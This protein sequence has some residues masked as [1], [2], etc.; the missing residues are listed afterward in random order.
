MQARPTI[1]MFINW[2]TGLHG[3]H[4]LGAADSARANGANLVCFSGKELGHPDHF[5]S[6][7]SVVFDLAKAERVDGLIVW[8]TTLQ[9]FVGREAMEAFCHRFDPVPMVSVEQSMAGMPSLV[10][11]EQQGMCEVVSHLIE[12]HGHRRIA[13]VRG[14]VNHPGAQLRYLGYVEALVRHGIAVDETL[15]SSAPRFWRPEESAAM[16]EQLLDRTAGAIDAIATA[17]DDLALGAVWALQNRRIRVP[18]D[19]AVV[20]FDD[21]VNVD[22][23]DLGMD[24]MGQDAVGDE[25][26]GL[27]NSVTATLPLTTVRSPMYQLGWRSVEVMLSR[28]R[29]EPVPAQT[30][31]PTQVVVR[32]SC[33][34]LPRSA[35]AGMRHPSRPVSLPAAALA[36]TPAPAQGSREQIVVHL[37]EWL[38]PALPAPPEDWAERLVD[39]FV[40]A[41]QSGPVR[42]F[43]YVLDDLAH[44]RA[45][46]AADLS[47]WWP[48]LFALH[49]HAAEGLGDG[50][51]AAQL[52]ELWQEVQVIMWDW[53]E[54]FHNYEQAIA[55]KRDQIVR[56]IGQNLI[57][58]LD[59][60]QLTAVLVEELPTIGITSCYV[61]LYEPDDD[62]PAAAYPTA[63]SRS[64]LVYDR[65]QRIAIAPGRA[66]FPSSQLV[67]DGLPARNDARSLVVAPLYFQDKQLG[68]VVTEGRVRDGWILEAL[69]AQLSSA[70]QGAMLVEREKR[71]LI[72]VDKARTRAEEASNAKSAFLATMSHELRTPLN[73][74]LG[75]TKILQHTSE[76]SALQANGLQTIQL[77]GE[78]LLT[79]IN[80]I[81]DLSKIDADK[82]ELAPTSVEMP[83]FMRVI[84]DI[85]RVKTEEKG[86]LFELEA[87]DLPPAVLVDGLRLRQVL[88]NLLG[89]AVK[90]TDRGRVTLR[91][92]GRS[93]LDGL[94]RLRFEV[95]D[96][97]IGIAR[98]DLEVIFNPFE[99]V[100]D[101]AHRA[102]GSGLGLGISR[103]L[104]RL[105]G[106]DIHVDSELGVGSRFWFEFAAP[107]VSS[108]A[109]PLPTRGTVTGY[110]GPRKRVL[111]VDDVD[112]N[113][114][115]LVDLLS[116]LGFELEQASDGQQALERAAATAPD[117]VLMDVV[118]PVMDGMEAT[119]RLRSTAG[120]EGLPVIA[121]SANASDANR[122]QC[123]AAGATAFLT[124]PI[125]HEAL[126]K[127]VGT[128][129]GLHWV[130]APP[131]A[132]E[133][134]DD[135]ALV[136]PP[137]EDL[138]ALH[139]LAQIGN[140]R[141]IHQWANRVEALDAR[142]GPVA[143][144]LRHLAD[145]YHSRAILTLASRFVQG[146]G[147]R[148]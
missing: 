101:A 43:L 145:G 86:I 110:E 5:Y 16:V 14:P 21:V 103:R 20:G 136:L 118:M 109:W 79:L 133:E 40:A 115:M 18:A 68:F 100:G 77:S 38:D 105:M 61:A 31:I 117:L 82:L 138:R 69:R 90:F 141:E 124:K 28:I 63:R 45:R 147:V 106:G 143:R 54:R 22:R 114:T 93:G 132:S 24:S 126:L 48:A 55:A 27:V 39:T 53:S 116:A 44:S 12:V 92:A 113:R 130:S 50:A 4:W 15:V 58:T 59:I 142:Y 120:F 107:V 62:A 1:G 125:D 29:G 146:D 51:R 32:R 25:R 6:H 83:S 52:D 72:E 9:P 65:G 81:L 2:L 88:L 41:A 89:N 7:A 122:D 144:R 91:V 80:D 129:L 71:A 57:T 123:L 75:Y 37:R 17:N 36:V 23:P 102:R 112:A 34:C 84:S 46:N 73:G 66:L 11:G 98:D 140:M 78:H 35:G 10:V 134:V 67:P 64:I 97:G 128:Q 96:T 33:G 56:Q 47:C 99:Q 85:I 19:I 127:E 135:A 139:R 111:V 26:P 70:V 49:R 13:F 95:V 3:W 148:G 60:G 119:R 76:L 8:T 94:S 30:T 108:K 131:S 74:I 104:V 87:D 137:P 42:E 121:L